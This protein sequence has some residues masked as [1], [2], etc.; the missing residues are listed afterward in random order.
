LKEHATDESEGVE[1][2]LL[3]LGANNALGTVVGLN[4]WQT[5]NDPNNRPHV[6]PHVEREAAGWTLWHPADFAAEYAELLDRVDEAM[7]QNVY[8]DW[9]IF[10]GTVPAVTIAPLAKGVGPTY[11]VTRKNT[12][13]GEEETYVYYKYY[14]YF[15]FEEDLVHRNDGL[16]LTFEDALHIDD[17]IREYN[18]TIRTLIEAKN[19][20]HRKERYHVVDV[21]QA[22]QDIA[23]KRNAGRVKYD[24]PDYFNFAYPKVDTRYYHADRDGRLRRGGLSGLDG[25]HPSAIGQGLLAHEFLKVMKAAGVVD[26]GVSLDWKA[27]F[28]SD[29]LYSDP[30]T[31]MQEI[32]EHSWLAEKILSLVR[33][34]RR[35]R[36]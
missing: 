7:S 2:L 17:C 15:L 31:I 24:F 13:T 16:Y 22:F 28:E 19:V 10:V 3:W 32:Y 35:S 21:F 12:T 18:A 33:T 4:I 6:L 27:I 30:I 26:G 8:P 36:S 34:F 1:N 25:V 9:K 14:V 20:K 23:V 29:A 5:P 11:Q